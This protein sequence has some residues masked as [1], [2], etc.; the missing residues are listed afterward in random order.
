MPRFTLRPP[1]ASDRAAATG[2]APDG[3]PG[4]DV[5]AGL[6]SDPRVTIVA[7]IPRLLLIDC[8]EAVA[9]EWLE[10]LPGWRLEAEHRARRP[11]PRPRLG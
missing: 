9:R 10:R 7:E 2:A 4:T 5:P 8:P 11:D 1:P 6:R 3:A